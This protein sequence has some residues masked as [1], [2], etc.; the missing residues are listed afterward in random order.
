MIL[1]CETAQ[2]DPSKEFYDA[3]NCKKSMHTVLARIVKD[4]MLDYTA[5]P[6]IHELINES[7]E[8]TFGIFELFS[9]LKDQQDFLEN[10]DILSK[11]KKKQSIK[12]IRSGDK[13]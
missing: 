3:S 1:I 5:G 13:Y 6:Y 4:G 12:I 10:L 7:D 8:L 11:Y 2:K 9:L